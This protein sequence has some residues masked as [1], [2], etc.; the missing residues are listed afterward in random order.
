MKN[1][2]SIDFK[3]VG[4]R[5]R[6]VRKSLDLTQE[7]AAELANITGQFWSLIETG[8]ERGSVNTYRQMAAVLGL[9]LNDLFYDDE[10]NPV[11][12][13]AFNLDGLFNDCT[14]FERRFIIELLVSVKAILHRLCGR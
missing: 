1:F 7:R 13:Q 11:I 6:K 2:Y 3:K 10:C 9:A 5:I 4:T 12:Q 14:D 8:K